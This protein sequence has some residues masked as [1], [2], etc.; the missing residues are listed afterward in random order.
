VIRTS[1]ALSALLV[2]LVVVLLLLAALHL[3]TIPTP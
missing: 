2:A 1:L 3:L